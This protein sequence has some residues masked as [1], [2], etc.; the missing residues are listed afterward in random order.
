ME[1][2]GKM[3]ILQTNLDFKTCSTRGFPRKLVDFP[4]NHIVLLYCLH[5]LVFLFPRNNF[6]DYICFHCGLL[7]DDL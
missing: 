5:V 3:Q 4:L 1:A 6:R 2:V 7:L